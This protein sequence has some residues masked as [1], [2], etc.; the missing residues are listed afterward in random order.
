MEQIKLDT[1][2]ITGMTAG[3][4]GKEINVYRGIPYAAPP[5][6]DLRWKA[7]QAPA[8]WKGVRKCTEFSKMAPQNPMSAM[9]GGGI[10]VDSSDDCLYLNVMVPANAKTKKLPVMVWFHGGMY[11]LGSGN[12]LLSNNYRLPQQG[13]VQV[14]VNHRLDI[15][16]LMAHPLLSRESG[17]GVSGNYMFLDMIASLQWV[18]R[19]IAAFGGDPGNVTIFGESGGGAKV[20]TLMASPLAKGLFHRVICESGTAAATTWWTG[21]PL[22]DMEAMG[23]KIFEKAGVKTLAEARAMPYEKFYQANAALAQEAKNQWGIVNCAVDGWFLKETPLAAFRSGKF[24]AV[25]LIC[26]A[27]TGELF[28]IFPMLVPGYV[29]ML[30][31]LEKAGVNGYACIFN[32]VPA[33]WRADSMKDAPHGLELLYVF[34]DYDNITGW[35]DAT[36]AMAGMM[37]G[38]KLKTKDPGLD[39]TDK[40]VSES[41]MKM[42]AQFAK[43][44]SPGVKGLAAWPV[45]TAANDKYLNID[46]TLEIKEGFSLIGQKKQ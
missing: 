24:N 28:G 9:M 8:S 11:A 33:N 15:V 27:N 23:Q 10:K 12:D 46:K 1:G 14:N 38:A 30:K 2:L 42:W 26:V 7:P 16:G 39:L 43:T 20:S 21:H 41:M 22:A 18:K 13:V 5:V 25:P 45:Y 37:G 32:Q 36:F 29:E 17:K 31:G 6:G 34:G 40:Y 44:G 3:E 19:N 4:K 35:W